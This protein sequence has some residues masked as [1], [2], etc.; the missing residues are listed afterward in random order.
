MTNKNTKKKKTAG[1]PIKVYTKKYFLNT[2]FPNEKQILQAVTM[3]QNLI[4]QTSE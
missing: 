4:K 3:D 1:E 2:T